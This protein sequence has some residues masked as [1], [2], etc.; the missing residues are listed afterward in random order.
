MDSRWFSICWSNILKL[1]MNMSMRYSS[2]SFL[3]RFL[4][5]FIKL[6]VLFISSSIMLQ[7][8]FNFCTNSG[9]SYFWLKYLFYAMLIPKHFLDKF[10][11]LL[12]KLTSGVMVVY[13][14]NISCIIASSSWWSV[15]LRFMTISTS[16]LSFCSFFAILMI[17][18]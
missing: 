5:I 6:L 12:K 9:S 3:Y 4:Y 7:R 14:L 16:M 13:E 10:K 8:S 15:I 1:F 17:S 18:A 2:M 11:I